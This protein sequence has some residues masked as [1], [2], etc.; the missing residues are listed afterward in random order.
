M[1][2]G[3]TTFLKHYVL[4]IQP[5]VPKAYS[6]LHCRPNTRSRAHPNCVELMSWK[7]KL[8]PFPISGTFRVA[9]ATTGAGWRTR[10]PWRRRSAGSGGGG[11]AP[12][13]GIE[14]R[15]SDI[16]VC[17]RLREIWGDQNGGFSQPIA[18]NFP[19]PVLIKWGLEIWIEGWDLCDSR[20]F[21]CP[22][23]AETRKSRFG[24]FNPQHFAEAEKVL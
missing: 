14:M 24:Q 17:L 4:S 12:P 13:R 16:Q 15:V 5:K 20:A 6:K 22:F 11:W 7:L 10:G 1:N 2:S 21:Y 8:S 3:E 18:H 23:L 19:S 9:L